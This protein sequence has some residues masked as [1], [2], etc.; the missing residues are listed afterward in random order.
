MPKTYRVVI[1]D[2]YG[3]PER[4]IELVENRIRKVLGEDATIHLGDLQREGIVNV[5]GGVVDDKE[6]SAVV[7]VY[8]RDY[9]MIVFEDDGSYDNSDSDDIID[10]LGI[11]EDISHDE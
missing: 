9:V 1:G 2:E 6:I 10:K 5:E 4:W 11:Q 8:D 7:C 3:G